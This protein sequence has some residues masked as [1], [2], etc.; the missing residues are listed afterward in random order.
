VVGVRRIDLPWRRPLPTSAA[1]H[2]YF[3]YFVLDSLKYLIPGIGSSPSSMLYSHNSVSAL[4]GVL[5]SGFFATTSSAAYVPSVTVKNGTYNGV[6]LP[7]FDQDIFLGIPYSL[8]PV[9]PY[10]FLPARSLNTS[11][12]GTRNASAYGNTCPSATA[13]DLS[14]PYGMSEDCLSLNVVRP[15]G[16]AGMNLPILFWIHGG[17]Y[18]SGAASLTNYNLSYIV[19]RSV[20]MGKPIIAVSINYRKGPWGLM[21]GEEIKKEGV[22]NLAIKDALLALRWVK[23]NLGAFGGDVGAVT[24]QGESAGSFMVGQLIVAG[25]GRMERLFHK[26]IQESG[27]ASTGT[28]QLYTIIK[29]FWAN[30]NR[31][32][33]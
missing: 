26:A 33:H 25:A 10:R 15:S 31:Q 11:W 2:K 7:S 6:Y 1:L 8:P 19:D 28:C 16:S 21:Y 14:L 3:G 13:S 22:E 32:W 18:Q 29:I 9:A 23:E 30:I 12:A 5:V 27:S 24:I 20:E 17:S 4:L